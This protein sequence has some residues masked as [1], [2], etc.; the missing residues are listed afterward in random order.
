MMMM[1]PR[2]REILL[3]LCVACASLV[4]SCPRAVAGALIEPETFSSIFHG[5]SL[6]PASTPQTLG[7]IEQDVARMKQMD[8]DF[9]TWPDAFGIV[10]LKRASFARAR[11]GGMEEER[12]W[13]ILGR[14]GLDERWLTWSV[15]DPP[16]GEAEI[17]E[18]SVW[19]FET[20]RKVADVP[21][22]HGGGLHVVRAGDVTLPEPFILVLAWRATRH[23]QLSIEGLCWM[24]EE[25][26]VW[27]SIVEVSVPSSEG[28]A[29][30]VHRAFPQPMSPEVEDDGAERSYTWRRIN[31]PPLVPTS[32]AVE[33]RAGVAISMRSDSPAGGS[34]M[35]HLMK[36]A[37]TPPCP[38]PPAAFE[39]FRKSKGEGAL[40]LLSWLRDQPE[41]RVEGLRAVP[42]SAPW[43]REE[44]LALACAWLREQGV[45]AS[46]MWRMPLD[47]DD[48]LPLCAELLQG[49]VLELPAM[50]GT[51]GAGAA[52]FYDMEGPPSWG[53]PPLLQ[54]A[55]LVGLSDGGRPIRKKI[56]SAKA[57][58]ARLSVVMDL[59][60]DA[61]GALRGPVRA[62]LRGAWGTLLLPSPSPSQDE[63]RGVVRA[64]FPGL[65]SY[66]DLKLRRVKGVPELSFELEGKPGV[67]GSGKGV[68]GILPLF[69]PVALRALEDVAPP[70]ELRFPFIVEQ[71]A[72]IGLPKGAGP[73]LIS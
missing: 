20:G 59:K 37:A 41:I 54:G 52:S 48:A 5:D 39:G 71:S 11:D 15:P 12:L 28:A 47:L 61:Q 7:S 68:L 58:E 14:R 33:P 10:W 25:L 3:A 2:G 16:G 67:S 32:L 42:T 44:K 50:K 69:E 45:D 60:L 46:L 64:L 29:T 62:M 26:P 21:T 72:T 35:V 13:T 17:L 73:A 56:P 6:M 63:L 57:D 53:T 40:R 36:D 65:Q 43:T 51:K 70:F 22:S 30:L 34:G 49:P 23:E 9:T 24:Q 4:A 18:A 66:G 38:A 8:P 19:S 55:K 27:E 1:A 31:V